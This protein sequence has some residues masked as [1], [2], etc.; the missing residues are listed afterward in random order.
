[1]ALV[2]Y[3]ESNDGADDGDDEKNLTLTLMKKTKR[4]MKMMKIQKQAWTKKNHDPAAAGGD[5]DLEY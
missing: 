1:M 5:G 4:L 3:S 2:S